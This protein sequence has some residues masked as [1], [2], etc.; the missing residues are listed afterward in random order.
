[1]KCCQFANIASTFLDGKDMRCAACG[2]IRDLIP[3][4]NRQAN[5]AQR[6]VREVITISECDREAVG[7]KRFAKRSKARALRRLGKTLCMTID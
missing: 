7:M 3:V 1:M 4:E 5:R 6:R 2:Q